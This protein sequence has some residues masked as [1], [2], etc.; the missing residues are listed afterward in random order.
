MTSLYGH[1]KQPFDKILC[2]YHT[3][4]VFLCSPIKRSEATL[5]YLCPSVCP[6]ITNFTYKLNISLS[7]L[8]YLTYKAHMWYKGTSAKT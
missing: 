4:M 8:N 6:S 5:L 7:L 1:F 3:I 2:L